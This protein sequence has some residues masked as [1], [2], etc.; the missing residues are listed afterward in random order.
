[1]QPPVQWVQGFFPGVNRPGNDADHSPSSAEV[2][3]EWG[4]DSV[5][6]TRLHGVQ[7]GKFSFVFPE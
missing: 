4:N 2:T 6:P 3:N 1:M 7:G 5:L